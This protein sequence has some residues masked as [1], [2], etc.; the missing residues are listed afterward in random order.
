MVPDAIGICLFYLTYLFF[1]N[2]RLNTI[3]TIEKIIPAMDNMT[4]RDNSDTCTFRSRAVAGRPAARI[5]RE[6][7]K[8]L[9]SIKRL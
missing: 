1:R 3:Q 8:E 7:G 5:K 2:T 6:W 4:P 9:Y